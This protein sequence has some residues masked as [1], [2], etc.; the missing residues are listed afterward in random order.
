VL[1]IDFSSLALLLI[2]G[3]PPTGE[4]GGQGE[5]DAS[6]PS[7]SDASGNSGTAE[8]EGS[9]E[10][11][12]GDDAT[13]DAFFGGGGEEE[14]EDQGPVE[15]PSELPS[16]DPEIGTLVGGGEVAPAGD[17]DM[18][19]IFGSEDA[20]DDLPD[21]DE[22]DHGRP[23]SGSDLFS[24]KLDLRLRIVSSVHIDVDNIHAGRRWNPRQPTLAQ[25]SQPVSALKV[26]NTLPRGT[27]SRN[28]NRIELFFS[29]QPNEH[30]QIVGDIEPVF[31]GVS[32][33]SGLDDLSSRQMLTPFHVES[34]AAYIAIYDALPNLDIKIGRQIVVWGTADKFNP[35]NNINADDLEDR[36]VFTEPIA[37]Q[38]LVVDFSPLQDR[39]W[40][41]GVYVPLFYPALLPPSASAALADP[42]T[43]VNFADQE[44]RDKLAFL[45]NFLT[46]NEKFNPRVLTRV[47][48]PPVNIMN[49]QVAFKVGTRLGPVDM[50]ASYYYGFHDIPIPFETE[51]KG[52]GP[53]TEDSV[54]GYWFQSD[55]TLV[56]PRMHVAGLDFA[57]QV[58][59]LDDMGLWGEAAL[60]F[61][62]Q[63]YDFRIE[64]PLILDITP[65]DGVANP[66]TEFSGAIVKKQPFLK[67]T[68]GADYTIGKHVYVQAQYL[69][70]FI[71]DFGAGNIGNY[72]LA[73]TDII[74]FGRHLIFR[75]FSVTEL[76]SQRNQ[77]PSTVL[78]PAVMMTP[79]WGFATFEVGGFA[80]VG[81]N[82]SKFGQTATGS[83][84]A[85]FKVTGSF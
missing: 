17:L 83:S 16:G 65:D 49:G 44:E 13:M 59:F 64:M 56:Y 51:S 71:D 70:G 77:D 12:E 2:L 24:G 63:D 34:D 60:I 76:P 55:V 75:A 8:L 48:Q 38:M 27:V 61:P 40:F 22:V 62:T 45:Q 35:T 68:V 10:E 30:I 82:T 7:D 23:A 46:A 47:E 73:G 84:I 69:R 78:A 28:E 4:E 14:E 66:V 32:Q 11:D 1:P 52:L 25:T 79:P 29:Y 21:I 81:K 9:G 5:T 42:Q 36:P 43:P 19:D 6:S 18:S 3:P 50:S 53:L 85:Y 67:A 39:L 15:G 41:Q 74:F 57:A 31:F 80:I 20:I 58:P 26:A 72:L 54:D 37:N 33:V